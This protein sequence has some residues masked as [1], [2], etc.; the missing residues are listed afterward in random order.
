MGE[1]DG[2]GGVHAADMGP[3][4]GGLADVAQGGG[5][6]GV[7]DPVEG[8]VRHREPDLRQ[9]FAEHLGHEPAAAEGHLDGL[10]ERP[11]AGHLAADPLGD[12]AA[13]KAVEQRQR[14]RQGHEPGGEQH[15]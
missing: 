11:R 6:G 12:L 2:D 14:H 9:P 8:G 10:G 3:V 4:R 15:G 13:E 7:R 5:E 1:A